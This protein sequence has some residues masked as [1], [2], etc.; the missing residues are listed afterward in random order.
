MMP[1]FDTM[2]EAMQSPV[3]PQEAVDSSREEDSGEVETNTAIL[4][5]ILKTVTEIKYVVESGR[6]GITPTVG[7]ISQQLDF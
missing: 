6:G 5:D 2:M 4:L 1:D 3:V 7:E